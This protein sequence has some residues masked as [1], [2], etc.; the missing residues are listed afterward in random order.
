[1][2]QT[3]DVLSY[4][5][6]LAADLGREYSR[7]FHEHLAWF[8]PG[9]QER[10]VDTYMGFY[11]AAVWRERRLYPGV[12][13]LL[14]LLKEN[15]YRTGVLS[16]KRRVFGVPEFEHSALEAVIDR[17]LFFTDGMAPKTDPSGLRDVMESL[18]ASVESVPAGA[19]TSALA[20]AATASENTMVR[21]AVSPLRTSVSD[22]VML[23]IVFAAVSRVYA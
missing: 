19:V 4:T 10:V 14:K 22:M 8:F 21:V 11:H 18:E 2:N 6:P 16:D 20:K 15:G 12:L 7:P 1:M 5:R 23:V 17:A 13:E 3:A 9:D